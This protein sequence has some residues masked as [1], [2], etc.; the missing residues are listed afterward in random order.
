M[1]ILAKTSVELLRK[2]KKNIE[3]LYISKLIITGAYRDQGIKLFRSVQ[4]YLWP[5]LSREEGIDK[6]DD[7][8]TD[9]N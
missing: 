6:E 3:K 1:T 9:E 5:S 8:N 2:C 7:D 4:H